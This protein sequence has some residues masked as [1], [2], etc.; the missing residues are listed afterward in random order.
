MPNHSATAVERGFTPNEL[1]KILRVSAD[2]I[3]DWIRRG[4]LRALNTATNRCGRPRFVVLPHHLAE[5]ER[6]HQVSAPPKPIP[7]RRRRPTVVD[8]YPD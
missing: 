1:A 8:Y 7:R 6:L 5:F 4:E 2:R 3:R